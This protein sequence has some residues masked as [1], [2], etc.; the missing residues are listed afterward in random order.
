MTSESGAALAGATSGPAAAHFV[1]LPHFCPAR[2]IEGSEKH[3]GFA[4]G[5]MLPGRKRNP[6]QTMR[7][8][9]T[10]NRV[11]CLLILFLCTSTEER[12]GR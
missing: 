11:V 12:D 3:Y 4:S 10:S 9:Q 2:F 8:Q 7:L 5:V 6:R 1:A